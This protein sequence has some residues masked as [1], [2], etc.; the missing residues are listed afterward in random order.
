[1]LRIPLAP[2][3][4]AEVLEVLRSIQGPVLA[5]LGCKACDIYED[6]G[7]EPAVVL[8]ERWESKATLESH[9]RSEAY[10]R[11]LGAIELA[12]GPP[13]MTFDVVSASEG[14]ELVERLR[15]LPARPYQWSDPAK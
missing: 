9:I 7:Q 4:H 14:M 13:E 8:L 12:S 3:R 5:Q 10:R 1:M 11:I 2:N 15:R 6:Q